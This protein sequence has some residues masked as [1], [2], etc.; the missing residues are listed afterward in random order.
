[1][2]TMP[3][4]PSLTSASK[5]PR[6]LN[7]FGILMI[8]FSVMGIA[9]SIF[10]FRVYFTPLDKQTGIMAD[11]LRSDPEYA[12]IMRMVLVPSFI[13]MFIQLASGIGLLR[14]REWARKLAIFNAVYALIVGVFIGYLNATRLTPFT[15]DHTMQKAKDP[16]I[17]NIMKTTMM[18]TQGVT[19]VLIAAFWIVAIVM[20]ARTKVRV[21]CVAASSKPT[22]LIA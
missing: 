10:S 18:V 16:A 12:S 3:L 21:F 20:L 19:M 13:F 22:N 2:E 15:L 7:V 8:A 14:A 5:R 9:S 6:S 1:M 11:L 17:A 4:P